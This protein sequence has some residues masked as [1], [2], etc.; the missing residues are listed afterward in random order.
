VNEMKQLEDMCAA[1]PP[2]DRDVIA[3][4]RARLLAEARAGDGRAR[5]AGP[6]RPGQRRLITAPRLALAGT[7]ALAL[8]AA[9]T[10]TAIRAGAPDQEPAMRLDAAIVLHRAALA[11]KADPA[12]RPGQ[13]L[14]VDVHVVANHSA[15]RQQIWLSSADGRRWHQ[16]VIIR[17]PC[18]DMPASRCTLVDTQFRGDALQPTLAWLKTLLT[19]PGPLLSYLSHHN[20]CIRSGWPGVTTARGAYS[21]VYSILNSVYVLPRALGAAVFNAAARIKGVTLLRHIT[22]AAGGRGIAVAMTARDPMSVIASPG[23]GAPLL[24]YELIFSPRTYR[25]IGLQAVG[26]GGTVSQASAVISARATNTAPRTHSIGL[27]GDQS[28]CLT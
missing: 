11:T 18:P 8:A 9:V 2:P 25:F 27:W 12:P 26:P 28:T 14:Y 6:G 22:D 4:A 1:V 20:S 13:F 16:G 10:T 15:Y 3:R 17:T 23:K 19:A 5:R 7:M 24:R 21:E